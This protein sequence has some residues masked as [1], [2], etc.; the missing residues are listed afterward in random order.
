MSDVRTSRRSLAIARQPDS[1]LCTCAAREVLTANYGSRLSRVALTALHGGRSRVGDAAPSCT[2]PR[3]GDPGLDHRAGKTVA[4]CH[5]RSERP[6]GDCQGSLRREVSTIMRRVQFGSTRTAAPAA[7]EALGAAPDES[8]RGRR[9]QGP[10]LGARQP[11]PRWPMTATDEAAGSTLV[12]DR[13]D[14]QRDRSATRRVH[15]HRALPTWGGCS[16]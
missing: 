5:E 8:D 2:S 12:G 4:T 6:E 14:R 1:A 11:S 15:D 10:E 16:R 3:R 7:L 9:A 13:R